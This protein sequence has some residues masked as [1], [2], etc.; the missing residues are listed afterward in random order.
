M[1]KLFTFFVLISLLG[2]LSAQIPGGNFENWKSATFEYPTEANWTNHHEELNPETAA[3]LEKSTEADDGTY[4]IKFTSME[5]GFSYVVWGNVEED[6]FAGFPFEDDPT[7]VTIAYK[8]TMADGDTAHL[9]V[10]LYSA[11]NILSEGKFEL[12]GTSASYTDHTFTLPAYT[13]MSDSIFVALVS[14]DPEGT[15]PTTAGNE[16]YFDNLRL[17]GSNNL[18][19]PDNSFEDWTTR[20]LDYTEEMSEIEALVEKTDDAHDGTYAMKMSTQNARWYEGKGEGDESGIDRDATVTLWGFRDYIRINDTTWED[21]TI[22]GL[23]IPARKD[24]LVFYY[25][26]MH[27]NSVLDTASAGLKFVKDSME[28]F[29]EWHTLYQT[30]TYTKA[31]IAFDLDNNRFGV[32]VVADSKMLEL[33]STKWRNNWLTTDVNVNGSALY[34]DYMYLAS[35]KIYIGIEDEAH[36]DNIISVFPNPTY[37]MLYIRGLSTVKNLEIISLSGALLYQDQIAGNTSVD[38]SE[39]PAGIYLIKLDQKLLGKIIKQ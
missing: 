19:I 31:E 22:G 12:N 7:Q 15:E 27:P 5:E 34:V 35:Q 23:A 14:S 3:L 2:A 28:V 13:G 1:K 20:V 16:L 10:F 6:R 37:D 32:S 33:E 24:T 18:Q 9:W 11:G 26:Y 25:K 17:N 4:A 39:Y 21:R 36:P 29:D 8:G 30:N 38:I